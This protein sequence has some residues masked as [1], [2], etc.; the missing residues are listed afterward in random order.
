MGWNTLE[1]GYKNR[2]ILI[3]CGHKRITLI[4]FE[5]FLE[6]FSEFSNVSRSE[7]FVYFTK[8]TAATWY[9]NN[10]ISVYIALHQSV[11][12]AVGQFGENLMSLPFEAQEKGKCEKTR[13]VLVKI[14]Q[15]VVRRQAQKQY[16]L[17]SLLL[18]VCS[19][20]H[21]YCKKL[22]FDKFLSHFIFPSKQIDICFIKNVGLWK[23]LVE[24]NVSCVV[25]WL[26]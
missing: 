20:V 15:C 9:I 21:H 6:M 12:C 25:R 17:N 14:T 18:L 2:Y 1:Q 24:K 16:V 11:G 23:L 8:I 3:D 13:V 7:T 26:A 19:A 22:R 5:T 10:I 4:C